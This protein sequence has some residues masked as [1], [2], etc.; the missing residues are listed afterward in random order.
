MKEYKFKIDGQDYNTTVD[1]KEKG[2]LTVTVN[3][4][5]YQVEVPE[6][7][8]PAPVIKAPSVMAAA[9][10]AV[11]RAASQP[12]GPST[13]SSPLPGTITTIKVEA[14]QHVK[15]GDVLIVMEAMKM[16]NDIL[17]EA[18]ATIKKVNVAVGQSVNQ[19]DALIELNVDVIPIA[20]NDIKAAPAPV[21]TPAKPVQQPVAAGQKTV[22]SPLPGTITKIEVKVGD[23]VKPGQ[24][25]V[26]LEAMKMENAIT[27]EFGGEVKAILVEQGEQ[28]QGGQPLVELA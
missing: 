4:K 19:G 9:A 8:A 23:M 7:K 16:A 5:T 26:F 3:G 18:D 20:V 1:E 14:G 13:V 22:T 28:V 25:V 6:T 24:N 21:A 11:P 10:V 27:A 2:K 12:A 15:K 17:A